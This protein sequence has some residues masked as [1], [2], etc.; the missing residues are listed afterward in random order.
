VV[1]L[2]DSSGE[3]VESYRYSPYGEADSGVGDPEADSPLGNSLRYAGQYLDS[4]TDLYDMRAREYDPGVGR[5][6]EV[7][8][9]EA[10]VGDPSVG[11]YVYVN[12]RPMVD[13]DPSGESA[14][15]SD[16]TKRWGTTTAHRHTTKVVKRQR[17]NDRQL[18]TPDGKVACGAW[19]V[20]SECG[21]ATIHPLEPTDS[22][23]WWPCKSIMDHG[24]PQAAA[25]CMTLYA[26]DTTY[27]ATLTI[28][29]WSSKKRITGYETSL[30]VTNPV[31]IHPYNV[32]HRGLMRI[33]DNGWPSSIAQRGVIWTNNPEAGSNATYL[34][35]LKDYLELTDF[36]FGYFYYYHAPGYPVR[37]ARRNLQLHVNFETVVTPTHRRN[38]RGSIKPVNALGWSP[39]LSP[40]GSYN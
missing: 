27:K 29:W 39:D 36:G 28:T 4:A 15:V 10:A 22:P 2:S 33:S 32:D 5:F 16:A 30:K 17:V 13:T 31:D 8:P 23:P 25:N 40:V 26:V 24:L 3:S 1:E 6:L 20:E 34:L 37:W 11:V 21:F 7:D 12:D 38:S 18:R 9:V 14:S 19:G 35:Y